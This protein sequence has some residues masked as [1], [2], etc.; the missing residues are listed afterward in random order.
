[1]TKPAIRKQMLARR[2]QMSGEE[3]RRRS[4]AVFQN[5]LSVF[6][7]ERHR[8]VHLFLSIVKFQELDTSP[9][10]AFLSEKHPDV[11]VGVP[12][13]DFA[14]KTLLHHE[15]DEA[16]LAENSWGIREPLE[17]APALKPEEFD[18]ALV[19]MLAFDRQCHRVGYGGGYYDKFL[20]QV[21]KDCHKFGLC[22]QFGLLEANL[23]PENFDV[24]VDCVI[25]DERVYG[26]SSV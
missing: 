25:T 6:N 1:M 19:P 15:Y 21:R 5:F 13:V 10:I 22:Y 14:A 2:R 18:L 20:A 12:R 24:A 26:S 4:Q 11:K 23:S 17:S 16:A 3:A 7:P 8:T 9:I